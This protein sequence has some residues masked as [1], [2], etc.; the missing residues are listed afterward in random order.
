MTMAFALLFFINGD[1]DES[2]TLYFYQKQKC[3]YTCQE[4][5]K[6][7]SYYDSVHCTCRLRWV[8]N[9]QVVIR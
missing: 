4:L 8:D 9:T 5:S 1:V 3:R 2:K 7:Q 6:D